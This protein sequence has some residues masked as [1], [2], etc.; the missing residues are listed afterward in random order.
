MTSDS[1]RRPRVWVDVGGTFTDCFVVRHGRRHAIKVLS[2]G[3]IRATVREVLGPTRLRFDLS[4]AYLASPFWA[5]AKLR[6]PG[7]DG[8][9]NMAVDKDHGVPGKTVTILSDHDGIFECSHPHHAAIGDVAELDAMIEA[10]VLAARLLLRA[11]LSQPLPPVDVRLGTTR[12]TNALLTRRGART[13]LLTTAGFGDL[14]EIGEQDR[15]DLFTLDI[16]KSAP[17]AETV[18]EVRQRMTAGGDVLIPIDQDALRTDLQGLRDLGIE[19]LAICF[20]HAHVNPQHEV[21]AS[22]LARDVG[23]RHVSCSSEVAPLIKLVTRAETTTLDAYLNPIL[24]DYVAT[25]WEQFGGSDSCRLRLMTSNGNL[26]RP[27]SFRG[28]D[29]ILSGPA[30]GVVA[31]ADVA[32]RAGVTAAVGLD[33]GGTSTDVSRFSGRVGRR[34]ESQVSG[35]RVMTPMMDIHTVAAGGGS[36]CDF[37]DGRLVVGPDSAGADPGPACYGRGGPL[38]VTDLNLLLGRIPESRFPISLD[39]QAA[40]DQITAICDSMT[41]A[42]QPPAGVDAAQQQA[43]LADGF[44]RIAVAHMSEAASA[45]STAEGIDVRTMSL[46]GFGG[47]A[48]QTLCRVASALGI[49]HVIDHPDASMLSAL[50]M[51]LASVGRIETVG[52]YQLLDDESA[53]PLQTKLNEVSAAA[54]AGLRQELADDCDPPATQESQSTPQPINISRRLDLRYAGTEA[55]LQIDADTIEDLEARFTANHRAVFGYHRPNAEIEIVSVRCEATAPV[56]LETFEVDD[57]SVLPNES[58]KLWAGDNWVDAKLIDRVSLRAGQTVAAPALIT[59]DFGTLVVDPGW[60]ASVKADGVIEMHVSGDDSSTQN[61]SASE[62]LADSV[63]VEVVARRLQGIADSMGEVLRRTAVSVNVK[64]RRD[65]SCAVFR[66]DGSLV[67]NAP[68]VP[69]HLGA[70]GHTVRHLIQSIN[71]MTDGDCYVSNDPLAGGSHLPDVTVVTPVFCSADSSS[72]NQDTR[73]EFFVASRAHHAEIGGKTPGSMPPDA[74]NLA[75]EGVLIRDFIFVNAGLSRESELCELLTSGDY[76]SRKPDENLADIRAQQAAGQHGVAA[77]KRL[78]AEYSVPIVDALMQRL[79]DLA[80]NAV[81]RWIQTLPDSPQPG[82]LL[83]FADALDDGTRIC[84]SI[85]RRADRI[86]IDF[87]G[88]AGVHPLCFNATPAI[89][90]AAVL[91]VLKC[92]CKTDL[93]LCDGVLR[94][95]DLIIP[96]GLLNPPKAQRAEDCAAVVAGNVE[97]SQRV[98]DVLLGAL[99]VAAASQGTMNNLLIGDESFGYYETICGGSGATAHQPGAAA[100]HTH[101]TNTRITDPEI[102]ESRMPVRLWKFSIRHGS[103]GLGRHHGGAG[104]IREL[105]FL[106]PLVVSL[107]TNRRKSSPYGI[108]GGGSGQPGKNSLQTAYSITDLESSLTISVN[109]GD[110]LLIQT[111]GGGGWGQSDTPRDPAA[112]RDS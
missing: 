4:D 63:L 90:T 75:Q 61:A 71:Q 60:I 82:S 50:G 29:S 8:D 19:S 98:V 104:A 108:A 12:G 33:M 56:P 23:F 74:S 45:V 58:I 73:P 28:R 34:F 105:E 92:V 52:L 10:P 97:T 20:L 53:E 100:V 2:S 112:H 59:N 91:Y 69:V 47:A 32:R 66:G 109:A 21:V 83:Q 42:G 24:R 107:L 6:F 86:R 11:A 84:V 77:I 27:E 26:V 14:L 99:G 76:P 31:L 79:L 80:G 40:R 110:R 101:M 5:G 65:Y 46:V 3:R 67:A 94:D 49:T 44:L 41:A 64:E 70:M 54:A 9:S 36:I 89:V 88:T 35:V 106:R 85:S 48:G 55:T 22:A 102:F 51:G 68:H 96:T 38:T 95:V 81:A 57:S 25:V 103:G 15:P 93:P 18:L 1:V 39:R 62:A 87:T 30:G 16:Q 13:A 72:D 43:K 7:R 17:I 111:P 37:I 78:A